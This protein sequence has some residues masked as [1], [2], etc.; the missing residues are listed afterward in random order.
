MR[1]KG[2]DPWVCEICKTCPSAGLKQTSITGFRW[3]CS[4]CEA[5]VRSQFGDERINLSLYKRVRCG[6]DDIFRQLDAYKNIA[7]VRGSTCPCRGRYFILKMK[8]PL[9]LLAECAS[10]V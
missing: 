2:S 8:S 1:K 3:L 4:A 5:Q 6:C 7:V 10:E 9:V